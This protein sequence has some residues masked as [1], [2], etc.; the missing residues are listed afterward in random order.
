M[1]DTPIPGQLYPNC[2]VSQVGEYTPPDDIIEPPEDIGTEDGEEW[3]DDW[4]GPPDEPPK[5]PPHES[6]TAGG[7]EIGFPNFLIRVGENPTLVSVED[8]NM[9]APPKGRDTY[10]S[11]AYFVQPSPGHS[12]LAEIRQQPLV[13]TG[14]LNEALDRNGLGTIRASLKSMESPRRLHYEIGI[15]SSPEA[16]AF[17]SKNTHILNQISISGNYE[18]VSVAALT[19]S[20]TE[21]VIGRFMGSF[22]VTGSILL[23][24]DDTPLTQDNTRSSVGSFS[25][26]PVRQGY[27]NYQSVV[28][29]SL[30]NKEEA[31]RREV[32]IYTNGIQRPAYTFNRQIT[33]SPFLK[34]P[35]PYRSIFKEEIDSTME[36][37][38]AI[39]SLTTSLSD[40]PYN[41]ITT[42]KISKSLSPEILEVLMAS[43]DLRGVPLSNTVLRSLKRALIL[44]E[45]D[46]YA[47]DDLL[48]LR[49]KTRV[50][51]ELKLSPTNSVNNAEAL[52]I[53]LTKGSSLDPLATNNIILK[54]Q[55][56]N[57]KIL[58]EDIDKR[59]IYKTSDQLET[60]IYIP[61]NEKITVITSNGT[62]HS[63]EMQDGDYFVADPL[64]GNKRL[65][66][67]SDR[68]R[69]IVYNP[70]VEGKLQGLLGMKNSST[71]EASSCTSSL[72]EYNVDTS[73]PRPDYYFL[74]LDKDT[75][76]DE[77]SD[78]FLIQKTSATYEYITT[79]IDE[80][81]KHKAFPGSVVRLNNDDML[82]NH[83][84]ENSKA[85]LTHIDFT[86]QY[87]S[88]DVTNI[89]VRRM[90]QHILV[91]PTDRL[92]DN[93]TQLR[94][95]LVDF[96]TRKIRTGRTPFDDGRRSLSDHPYLTA[97]Y[98]MEDVVNFTEDRTGNTIWQQKLKY[99][100]NV[101][102][103]EAFE[104]YNSGSEVLP[105]KKMPYG[106][107]L[108][109]LN[110]IK[111]VYGLSDRDF[112]QSYELYTRLKPSDFKGLEYDIDYSYPLRPK[113]RIGKPTPDDAFNKNNFV[114]LKE[115]TV[116]DTIVPS[117]LPDNELAPTVFTKQ[118]LPHRS[119]TE[120][121]PA[122]APVPS[123][124]E[125]SPG[126]SVPY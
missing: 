91:L 93:L 116:G 78:S 44:D 90:P 43:Y 121:I 6:L 106:M 86:L 50:K 25:I 69:A 97:E 76:Q 49:S 7:P 73:T 54:N 68:D 42:D 125:P 82:F 21:I 9:G 80:Y 124:S 30:T 89:V 71:L 34:V 101:T 83:L 122:P 29:V 36:R 66:V 113:L 13:V 5:D 8:V 102:A 47:Y 62:E 63:L 67:F 64:V 119:G 74:K 33:P 26:N 115:T 46:S 56:F 85:K 87:L 57:W 103:V 95:T 35:Y 22:T 24:G 111:T 48:S 31:E 110:N 51:E 40:Y 59:V 100:F 65:T 81:V 117:F 28:P 75:I 96:N 77:P 2:V 88:T 52:N 41:A 108:A 19:D 10:T 112:I 18:T 39:N 53:L 1:T 20:T 4:E 72:T 15:P 107:W 123:Q 3:G 84:E 16:L 38:I 45:L 109:E 94:S 60:P 61:N 98:D 17:Y 118:K 32:V 70:E 104:R 27:Q 23:S 92:V 105:R 126:T 79:G 11:R 14:K 99:S 12:S 55:L 58:A 37:I 120:A 114:K